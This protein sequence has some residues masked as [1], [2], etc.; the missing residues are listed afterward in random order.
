MKELLGLVEEVGA[1]RGRGLAD[2]DRKVAIAEILDKR[3]TEVGRVVEEGGH[4]EARAG[5][6]GAN[7]GPV[8]LRDGGRLGVEDHENR[9][10][11]GRRS[12]KVPARPDIP[13]ERGLAPLD[14]EPETLPGRDEA[15]DFLGRRGGR[16]GGRRHEGISSWRV[17]RRPAPR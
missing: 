8:L 11:A 15:R 6:G 9:G 3:C 12:A 7:R 16:D 17:P 4:P 14:R 5:E 2:L 13:G 1:L 10:A